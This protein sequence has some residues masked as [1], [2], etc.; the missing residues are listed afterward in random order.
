[1]RTNYPELCLVAENLGI[2]SA[3]VEA[4]RHEF[5]LPGMLILQFAFDGNPENPYLPHC[6]SPGDIVYTGTHDNDT[7]LGWF[8]K[9]DVGMQEHV[10]RTFNSPPEPMPW[11]LIRQAMASTAN[12][13]IIPWQDFLALD[14]EHRMNTP[15][16]LE[17]NWQWRFSW[18][19]VPQD[20]VTRIRVLVE[21]Y[22]RLQT[23]PGT[24]SSDH[25][26]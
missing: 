10:Y 25:K 11:M 4:L 5:D 26:A 19:Q 24:R 18:T 15:G 14:G 6:H 3:E 23:G 21:S 22:R 12:T 16:T 8:Q 2:I 7:T 1:V 20:T 13:A 9:L 17:G